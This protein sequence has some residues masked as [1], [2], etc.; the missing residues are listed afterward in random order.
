MNKKILCCAIFILLALSCESKQKVVP[1]NMTKQAIQQDTAIV[2][3][4]ATSTNVVQQT[5]ISTKQPLTNKND[6]TFQIT[7]AQNKQTDHFEAAY[8]ELANM[9][10]G[11]Q[12]PDLK[13]AV[14]LTENAWH[15]DKLSYADFCQQIDDIVAI[16][17]K[18]VNER[19]L[20][21]YKTAGNWAA[22][23]YLCKP[24]P[25]ND[26]KP[27]TYNFDDAFGG[28]DFTNT[29]VTQ[30][31][32][33]KGGTCHSL[34]LLYKILTDEYGGQLSHLAMAPNHMYIK[35]KDEKGTWFNL[36]LTNGH[37]SSDAWIISS[38]HIKAEAIQQKVYMSALTQQ[39]SIG[40]CMD[41]LVHGYVKKHGYG[42]NDNFLLRCL[43]ASLQVNPADIVAIG[44][45]SNALTQQL[46]KA[47][48]KR[49]IPDIKSAHKVPEL[50]ALAAEVEAIYKLTDDL[51]YEEMDKKA[52]NEWIGKMRKESTNSNQNTTK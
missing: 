4:L 50:Q 26:F 28:K 31:L 40:V 13:R 34:P 9:M 45:K 47:S 29:F 5:G 17:R 16:M 10:T 48:K 14:F 22:H 52:Y 20:E 18:M 30:L 37:F 19:G 25:E 7:Q 44:A 33:T 3:K 23:T 41:D 2:E 6:T 24:I 49:G 12:R 35:H 27:Y 1:K 39:E 32:A 8:E 21:A 51:G 15:N 46:L 38:S 11:K 42:Y 43:N 36:E